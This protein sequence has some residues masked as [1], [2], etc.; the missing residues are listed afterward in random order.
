MHQDMVALFTADSL[1]FF[2]QQIAA[3]TLWSA[4]ATA[5][6]LFKIGIGANEKKTINNSK[7]ILHKAIKA[8]VQ[9]P[10]NADT[11]IRKFTIKCH[12]SCGAIYQPIHSIVCNQS[13][14]KISE[15]SEMYNTYGT[16]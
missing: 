10:V 5:L 16:F 14:S 1:T 2:M 6:L 8:T 13:L 12:E 3:S 9:K 7:S 11:V 15:K 4:A